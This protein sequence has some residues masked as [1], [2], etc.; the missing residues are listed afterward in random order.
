MK[1]ELRM[2]MLHTLKQMDVTEKKAIEKQLFHHLTASTLWKNAQTIG[3][4]MSRPFEWNTRDL[5]EYAWKQNKK[6][7]IPRSI[8]ET[9]SMIFHE[10]NH[11]S[12]LTKG[13]GGIE[14]PDV[15]RTS[16]VEKKA[17]DL[18]IVPGL[19]FNRAGYRIGFGGGYYDRFLTDFTKGTVRLMSIQQ[20]DECIPVDEYAMPVQYLVTE[21]GLFQTSDG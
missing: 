8:T 20:L 19:V 13:Y 7:A 9:K 16:I 4:T 10:L 12:E 5:I 15:L 11:F 17:I 6:I 21:T 18:L 3:I 14:E 1:K 2:K